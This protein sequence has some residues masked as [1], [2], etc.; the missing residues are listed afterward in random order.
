MNFDGVWTP[1]VTPFTQEGSIDFPALTPV[2]D[3]LIGHGIRGLIV[4]GTT[5]EY[6]ALSNGDR[7][8]LF[9]VI[10]E[11]AGGAHHLDGGD[12]RHHHGREPGPWPQRQGRRLRLQ[13]PS[14]S[15]LLSADPGRA[16]IPRLRRG[17]RPRP[18]V[19]RPGSCCDLA[20]VCPSPERSGLQAQSF[21]QR[22]LAK[23]LCV[24]TSISASAR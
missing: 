21:E 16:A 15:P 11:L 1:V 4:G 5:G 14:R 13:P 17:R 2:I 24:R 9:D 12:Q 8:K 3:S 18:A 20:C 19:T 23:N 10:A 7:K 22:L 6:Y